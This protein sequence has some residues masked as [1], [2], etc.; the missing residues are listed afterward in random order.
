MITD[1]ETNTVYISDLLKEKFTE[2]HHD[3]TFLL[4]EEKVPYLELKN[5]RDI[6]CRDYM[7]IQ[8][9]S[10]RFIL[11]KYDPDYL[12]DRAYRHLGTEQ[13]AV[14]A[15]LSLNVDS[16]SLVIDGGN[17]VRHQKKVILTDK[18]FTENKTK[19]KQE[20]LAHLRVMLEVDE[21]II[22][23]HLP[24]DF[25]GHSDGM[26]RFVN[27]QTVM[28]NDFSKYNPAYFEKLKKSLT[29]HGLNITLLPWDG[30][31][32][33]SDEEDTGDY[34]NFLHVGNLIIVPEF[35]SVN[36]VAAK[37]VIRQAYPK[38]KVI[39]VDARRIALEGGLLNCCTWN[40]KR[41]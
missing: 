5:T 25:T 12:K 36:D 41:N 38:T 15:P 35:S 17:I 40:I 22:I 28:L 16:S 37:T 2:L 9:T 21:V 18:I 33:N 13:S 34:I 19:D 29:V 26:V 14:L 30:W 1:S 27:Q 32:N 3:L 20:I 31:K 24:N 8:L 11:F 39:G 7:P 10:D 4:R 23:P 6:W